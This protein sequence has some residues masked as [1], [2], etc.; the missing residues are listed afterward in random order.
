MIL[1]NH[2]L[3]YQL[4][5]LIEAG[6]F[7][8]NMETTKPD[9]DLDDVERHEYHWL[10][11]NSQI[12]KDG[13]IFGRHAIGVVKSNVPWRI[14]NASQTGYDWGYSGP[15]PSDLALNILEA[16]LQELGYDGERVRCFYGDCFALAWSNR[17]YFKN[18]FLAHL[19]TN[20]NYKLPAY[21]VVNFVK[22]MIELETKA[23]D[24]CE[25]CDATG[26][27]DNDCPNQIAFEREARLPLALQAA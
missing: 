24:Y 8:D 4:K 7:S 9:F 18:A 19:D 26:H 12:T 25:L 1:K 16:V 3:S 23:P 15:G 14:V 11:E 2:R 10:I 22:A 21:R 27:S 13:V 20:R 17:H 5:Q 6:Q